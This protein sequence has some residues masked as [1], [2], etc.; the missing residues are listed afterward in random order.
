MNAVTPSKMTAEEYL[1]WE[2]QQPTKHEYYQEKVYA[3]YPMGGAEDSHNTVAGNICILFKSHLRGTPCR[4]YIAD[5]KVKAEESDA[6]FYPDVF[7][8]CEPRENTN[9]YHKSQPIL[10][11]EVLSPS[12]ADYDR[13]DKFAAYRKISSLQEYVLLDPATGS[14][15]LYRKNVEGLWV[16]HP[17]EGKTTIEFASIGLNANIA[18]VF[19]DVE[20]TRPARLA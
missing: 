1:A 20:P 14:V 9:E 19:E 2:E 6:Y 12:T 17:S 8:T 13:G 4:A 3:V 15:D 10:I 7:V 18:D 5:M 11:V 16:L